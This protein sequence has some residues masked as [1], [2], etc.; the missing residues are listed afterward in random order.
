[1][2]EDDWG[3]PLNVGRLSRTVTPAIWAALMARDTGCAFPGCTR[4]A[5][6]TQ[7]HHII[8]WCDGGETSLQ[9]CVL[10]CDPHHDTV[11]HKGWVIRLDYHGI[12]EF[13]PPPKVDPQQRPRRNEH[14]RA[15]RRLN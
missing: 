9:N 7:A 12:P 11:H 5:A 14:W 8:H 10:L 1:V 4:P 3:Q 2:V 6:W 13:I 15:Q